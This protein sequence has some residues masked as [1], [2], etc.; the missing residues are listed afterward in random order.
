[1]PIGAQLIGSVFSDARLLA[2]GHAY[3]QVTDYHTKR[4]G[5][6]SVP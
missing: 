3:Q 5:E 4:P 1:M 6:V 2:V